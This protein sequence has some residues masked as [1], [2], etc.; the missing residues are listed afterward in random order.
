MELG[1]LLARLR[2][3]EGH[4]EWF[5]RTESQ[6]DNAMGQIGLLLMEIDEL[7]SWRFD[8]TVERKQS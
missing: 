7:R 6:R 1:G 2:M 3:W 8:N 4:L 5:V